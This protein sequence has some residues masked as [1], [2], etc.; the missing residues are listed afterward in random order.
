[1]SPTR[2]AV[3]I[4][5][6][7]YIGVEKEGKGLSGYDHLNESAVATLDKL[8]WRVHASKAG[9]EEAVGSIGAKR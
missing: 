5:M 7:P 3:H 1:M 9:R 8:A 4:G 2:T 6:E